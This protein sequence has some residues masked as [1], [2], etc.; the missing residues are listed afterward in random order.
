LAKTI[1]TPA[2]ISK[3]LKYQTYSTIQPEKK[4]LYRINI[5]VG[6]EYDE[7]F[8]L[9]LSEKTSLVYFNKLKEPKNKYKD[10]NKKPTRKSISTFYIP[11]EEFQ[12]IYHDYINS[13]LE[14][15][16]LLEK[17]NIKIGHLNHNKTLYETPQVNILEN[18][19]FIFLN[20]KMFVSNL[21]RFLSY[22]KSR[23]LNCNIQSHNI[24]KTIARKLGNHFLDLK[25][26]QQLEYIDGNPYNIKLE[27]LKIKV[28][29]I[30]AKDVIEK[31]KYDYINTKITITELRVKYG[32]SQN[33][34]GKLLTDC[35]KKKICFV[36]GTDDPEDFLCHNGKKRCD[37]C[38]DKNPKKYKNLS[39]EERKEK[40]KASSE[41]AKVNP[42]RVKL[43]GAR[44]RARS[45]GIDFD[46]DEEF[47]IKLYHNQNGKCFYSGLPISIDFNDEVNI[48]SIDR[49][50]SNL[51]YLKDNVCLTNKHINTMKLNLTLEEFFYFIKSIYE[52]SNL[53]LIDTIEPK[54]EHLEI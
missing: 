4:Y 16:Q 15:Y 12:P 8:K 7:F 14:I 49:I 33:T 40:I 52:F 45:K 39:I 27:N 31:I 36:C 11:K 41:W 19:E 2:T 9:K 54:I 29:K 3:L 47:V 10:K 35:K 43:L 22:D 24:A 20:K 50:D 17:Y 38:T 25:N 28:D 6:E 32:L 34:V 48:F 21:G 37:E 23:I 13:G 51:G 5:L 30:I 44:N 18:E 26:H 53:N 1:T 46:L 42:L